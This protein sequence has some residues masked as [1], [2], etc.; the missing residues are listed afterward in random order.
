MHHS[1]QLENIFPAASTSSPVSFICYFG[2]G[3][4]PECR[5]LRVSK[6]VQRFVPGLSSFQPRICLPNCP[7]IWPT[8]YDTSFTSGAFF[9]TV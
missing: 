2:F 1:S 6:K 5:H 9:N 4:T 3:P 7:K 8:S